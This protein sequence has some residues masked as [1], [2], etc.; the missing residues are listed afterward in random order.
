MGA[1]SYHGYLQLCV[2]P[3][4]TIFSTSQP[5]ENVQ[6]DMATLALSPPP[7]V[8][9]LIQRDQRSLALLTGETEANGDSRST[10]EKTSLVGLLGSEPWY[11]RFLSCLGKHYFTSFVPIVH[12]KLGKQLCRAARL[13]ICVSGL[14]SRCYRCQL[15]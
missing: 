1:Y 6:T 12:S 3:A 8:L 4:G 10:K 14:I 5:Y 2:Q 11:K 13:L 15:S 7:L 9:C